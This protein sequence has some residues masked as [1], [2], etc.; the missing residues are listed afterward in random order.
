VTSR[1]HRVLP[2]VLFVLFSFAAVAPIRSYDF[3]WHLATGRWIVEHRALPLTDPFAV[4]SDRVEWINGAWLAQVVAYFLHEVVGIAGLSLLRGICAALLFTLVYVFAA[5][6]AKPHVAAALTALG[7]AGAMPLLDVRPSGLA[8]LFVVLAIELRSWL[9]HALLAA[10]WVN[11]HSSALLAPVIAVFSTRRIAPPIAAAIALLI[12]P[13][14]FKAI[15]APVELMSYVGGGTFVN[16]EWLPSLPATFPLLYL[17]AGVG[18]L[19][20]ATAEDPRAQWWRA[21]LFVMFAYL[22]MRHARHQPLFFAA[23]PLLVA[24]AVR[25]AHERLA[26]A[27]AAACIVFALV[28]T[29][30]QLGP[31][32]GRFPID[33]AE[34]LRASG[35]RGNI[36]NADQFGGY[37]IW[38]FYP[39]R[40]VLTDGRN[41]LY[42]T[43]IPEVQRAREDQRAWRALLAKYRVD[44]AVEE[45]RPPLQVI[46]AVSRKTREMPASL[47][48]WP[49]REW[50]L[51]GYDEVAMVFARRAAFPPAVIERLEIEGRVP[52]ARR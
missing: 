48:Y 20:F 51:I 50:A 8:A 37:L 2:A 12:N 42:R 29:D 9:A 39:E 14:G 47:A 35:L 40:R 7:F 11:I 31:V 1:G 10:L 25:R 18:I 38:S 26:Y 22:A 33:A 27:V 5:R 15:T 28:T 4:A 41:E 49:R 45:Y 16:L 52:D 24:P 3:F 36:Y 43:F 34:Q 19:A 13:Y 17:A 6:H 30:H 32:R 21:A 46:D 44:L 23:F